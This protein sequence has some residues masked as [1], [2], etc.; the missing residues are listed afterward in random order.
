MGWVDLSTLYVKKSGD[1]MNGSLTIPQNQTLTCYNDTTAYNVGAT[2][3]SL[4]DSVSQLNKRPRV[5][6]G[7]KVVSLTSYH[8]ATLF[9]ASEA[10]AVV[11]RTLDETKDSVSICNG[12]LNSNDYGFFAYIHP[13]GDVHLRIIA[14]TTEPVQSGKIRVNYALF[15]AQ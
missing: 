5:Y 2:L 1:T 4:Q 14:T 12:D 15:I 3:K 6:I 9:T 8:Y 13:N 11:G 10:K 7:S